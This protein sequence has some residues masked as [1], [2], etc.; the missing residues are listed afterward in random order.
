MKIQKTNKKTTNYRKVNYNYIL[1]PK[2][3]SGY[4]SSGRPMRYVRETVD[5]TTIGG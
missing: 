2:C 5:G 3:D 1:V 4:N